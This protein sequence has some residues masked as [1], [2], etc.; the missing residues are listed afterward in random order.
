M[1]IISFSLSLGLGRSLRPGRPAANRRD[2][3]SGGT[4]EVTS[5]YRILLLARP[6]SGIG[7]GRGPG[8]ILLRASVRPCVRPS[9]RPSGW[10]PLEPLHSFF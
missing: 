7:G 1:L 9:V 6:R 4:E 5:R 3:W 10:I 2:H 8:A